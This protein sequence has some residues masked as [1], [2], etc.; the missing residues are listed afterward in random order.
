MRLR[1]IFVFTLLIC[2]KNSGIAFF[3]YFILELSETIANTLDLSFVI[4]DFLTVVHEMRQ[5]ICCTFDL[6]FIA[7]ALRFLILDMEMV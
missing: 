1:G 4:D 6:R 7:I 5:L 2:A 3:N